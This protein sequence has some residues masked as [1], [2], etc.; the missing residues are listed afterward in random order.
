ML[1]TA[2]STNGVCRAGLYRGVIHVQRCLP[3]ASPARPYSDRDNEESSN[4]KEKPKPASSFLDALFK[5][6]KGGT[7]AR[8]SSPRTSNT[9]S[10]SDFFS[11]LFSKDKKGTDGDDSQTS[12]RKDIFG[13]AASG[14]RRSS[15]ELFEDLMKNQKITRERRRESS[16]SM[17]TMFSGIFGRKRRDSV[18]LSKLQYLELYPKK[19]RQWVKDAK[20]EIGYY[21]EEGK[22]VAHVEPEHAEMEE[23]PPEDPTAALDF[24]SE[25]GSDS[26][27]EKK[28]EKGSTREE[29]D[30]KD[31]EEGSEEAVSKAFKAWTKRKEVTVEDATDL[32]QDYLGYDPN[33]KFDERGMLI[34]RQ[35]LG[36]PMLSTAESLLSPVRP[37]EEV[38]DQGGMLVKRM[39]PQPHRESIPKDLVGQY[40]WGITPEDVERA[41]LSKKLRVLLSFEYCNQSDINQFRIQRAVKKWQRDDGD[42]GSTPVQVAT[43]SERI[44]YLE[45]HVKVHRK[46]KH[47]FYGYM[48]LIG[49]RSR[50]LKYLMRTDAETYF[51]LITEYNIRHRNPAAR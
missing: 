6:S 24:H 18:P 37:G 23:E 19:L 2:L 27:D 51:K 38:R 28:A 22:W 34:R 15:R 14:A 26:D 30:E 29:K 8:S 49:R 25:E 40:K 4:A 12:V 3:V 33:D 50:L 7:G 10:K 42:T 5:S 17:E 44:R 16:D 46:D 20:T 21:N 36:K 39:M 13:D 35:P 41:G 1:S 48:K 31:K 43:L 11:S 32:M 45:Q 9:T 47:T